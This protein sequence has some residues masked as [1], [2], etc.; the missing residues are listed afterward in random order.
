MHVSGLVAG[1][2]FTADGTADVA[3]VRAGDP[4]PDGSG[5]LETARGPREDQGERDRADQQQE[6]VDDQRR[7]SRSAGRDHEGQGDPL[8]R[9]DR[10]AAPCIVMREGCAHDEAPCGPRRKAKK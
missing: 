4:A 1:R 7:Q 10:P 8:G 3:D 6:V 5:P 2:D 9:D